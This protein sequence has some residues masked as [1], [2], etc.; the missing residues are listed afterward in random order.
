MY[1]T[2]LVSF[3]LHRRTMCYNKYTAPFLK[4]IFFDNPTLPTTKYEIFR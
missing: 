1:T 4:V 2:I 3:Q